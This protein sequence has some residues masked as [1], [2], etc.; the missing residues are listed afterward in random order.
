MVSR[1]TPCTVHSNVQSSTWRWFHVTPCKV[2]YR[3]GPGDGFML[4]PAQCTVQSRTWRWLCKDGTET[5][6]LTFSGFQGHTYIDL[7]TLHTLTQTY[8]DI[9]R[10]FKLK[11]RN[12][13]GTNPFT[14]RKIHFCSF[15]LRLR[16]NFRAIFTLHIMP[17][18]N[19]SRSKLVLNSVCFKK[20]MPFKIFKLIF[21]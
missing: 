14:K 4:H 9:T 13:F 17:K 7:Y 8:H 2:K 11:G 3:V 18:K 12:K 1:Y 21:D 10:V 5:R 16:L 6:I 20:E 19:S 15:I